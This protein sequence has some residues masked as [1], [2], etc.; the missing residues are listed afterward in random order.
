MGEQVTNLNAWGLI[1]LSII[2]GLIFTVHRRYL[3]L[4]LIVAGMWLTLGQALVVFDLNLQALRIAVLSMMIRMLVRGE[5]SRIRLE[6]IDRLFLSWQGLRIV[7]FTLLMLSVGALLNRI[8]YALDAVSLYFCFRYAIRDLSDVAR[9]AKIVAWAMVPVATLMFVERMTGYNYFSI[10]GGIPAWSAMRDGII[11]CQG[12]FTHPILAGTVGALWLPVFWGLW[13]FGGN[14]VS[15]LAGSV[16]GVV[17]VAM[18]GSSGPILTTLFGVFSLCL[19]QIRHRMRLVRIGI[20]V[21]LFVVQLFMNSPIWYLL[22]RINILSASTGWHRSFLIDMSVKHFWQW[23]LVGVKDADIGAWGVWAADI[24]NHYLF[25]GLR[26][27][28]ATMCV[29]MLIIV[30][31]YST[32]GRSVSSEWVLPRGHRLFVWSLGALL[33]AHTATFF[34]VAYY[35]SQVLLH[36]HLTVAM[37]GGA[38]R[39][40]AAM[41]EEAETALAGEEESHSD[42]GNRATNTRVSPLT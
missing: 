15:A 29:F 21:S 39:A 14:R 33:V 22:A 23:F 17:M 7:S 5:F 19:W 27:G 18:S 20:V 36:W 28:L 3:P 16:A 41:R 1:G 40:V 4:P 9:A 12:P 24:T 13:V 2:I 10:L 32:I 30:R 35:D 31:L 38:G 25:E 11:R 34:S 42:D 37:I 6:A 26:G 8:A